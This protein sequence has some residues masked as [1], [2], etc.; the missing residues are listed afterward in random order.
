MA[1]P[2]GGVVS[3]PSLPRTTSGTILLSQLREELS[4]LP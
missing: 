2:L 3:A 1:L 4:G